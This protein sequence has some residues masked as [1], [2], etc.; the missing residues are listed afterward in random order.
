MGPKGALQPALSECHSHQDG[1]GSPR[2]SY[3]LEPWEEDQPQSAQ[4]HKLQ[5]ELR[6]VNSPGT[7]KSWV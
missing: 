2:G 3:Q 5:R 4:R 1:F 6:P 7:V